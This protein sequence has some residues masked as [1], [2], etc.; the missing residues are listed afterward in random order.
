MYLG[1]YLDL[2]L[3][4]CRA[5][6]DRKLPSGERALQ[7]EYENTRGGVGVYARCKHL[8]SCPCPDSKSDNQTRKDR[9]D[10]CL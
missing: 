3:V 5:V 10:G 7:A 1:N 8:L 4:Y 6:L 9:C 2:S